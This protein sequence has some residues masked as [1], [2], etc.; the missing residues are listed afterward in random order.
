MIFPLHEGFLNDV[1]YRTLPT[2]TQSYCHGNRTDLVG[3]G[4]VRDDVT[5][6]RVDCRE[7]FLADGVHELV[8]DEKLE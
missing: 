1:I 4:H 5:C 6:G 7:G 3:F 8:V 2:P